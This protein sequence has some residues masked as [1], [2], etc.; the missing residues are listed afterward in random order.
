MVSRA[1]RQTGQAMAEAVAAG[2]VLVLFLVLIPVLGRY[3]DLALHATHASRH[4]AFAAT[5]QDDADA[6][7]RRAADTAF[8][9]SARRWVDLRGQ[10]LIDPTA[11]VALRA[12]R[13]APQDAMQ[14]GA[15]HAGA[16]TLRAEWQIVD[17]GILHATASVRPRL[18]PWLRAGAGEASL[19]SVPLDL[20]ARSAAGLASSPVLALHRHTA[21]LTG[22]EGHATG[23]AHT[24]ARVAGAPQAW[25]QAA[26]RSASA[27][28]NVADRVQSV[29]DPWRR[30]P[31]RFDWVSDWAGLVPSDRV[32]GGW[33]P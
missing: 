28:R 5:R 31:P 8:D 20:R 9:H 21:V 18:D 26:A 16:S 30:P 32:R 25:A 17:R 2:G 19:F 1:A 15:G 6:A 11:P 4:A 12:W 22:R 23:D 14:P 13:D 10:A 7:M 27:G 33:W 3:Q 24:Q 29:D